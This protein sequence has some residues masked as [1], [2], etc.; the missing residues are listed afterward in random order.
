MYPYTVF[1]L[2]IWG[3]TV[4]GT[5]GLQL[6]FPYIKEKN[7]APLHSFDPYAGFFI[8]VLHIMM[9]LFNELL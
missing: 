6:F 9:I 3:K 2:I 1:S 5:C 8:T 4:Q 7:C